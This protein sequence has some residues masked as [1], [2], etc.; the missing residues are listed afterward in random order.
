M[1]LIPRIY[2]ATLLL[3]LAA[4][5]WAEP[6]PHTPTFWSVTQTDLIGA[7]KP[8]VMG[9]PQVRTAP[10]GPALFFNGSHDGLLVPTNPL[11][12]WPQFTVEILFKPEEGG[13]AEQRFVHIQDM[14]GQMQVY[15]RA[16]DISL[17][18]YEEFRR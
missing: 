5:L 1:P 7:H 12:G 8:T 6:S 13:L 2:L 17:E 4:T 18:V 3:P 11:D 10:P 14:S 9:S 16:E 15:L